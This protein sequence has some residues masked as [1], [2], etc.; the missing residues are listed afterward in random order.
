[1]LTPGEVDVDVDVD[2]D[3]GCALVDGHDVNDRN[4]RVDVN[5]PLVITV[6]LYSI[7]IL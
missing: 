7:Y 5:D 4:M 2:V 6:Q 3:V 1:M